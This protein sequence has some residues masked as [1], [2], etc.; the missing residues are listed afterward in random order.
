MTNR[1][2][3]DRLEDREH[4]SQF[5]DAAF[6]L[7]RWPSSHPPDSAIR[8]EERTAAGHPSIEEYSSTNRIRVKGAPERLKTTTVQTAAGPMRIP[9][10]MNSDSEHRDRR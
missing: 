10:V 3:Y 6:N 2:V 4:G 1:S 9:A 7:K 5:F 8:R